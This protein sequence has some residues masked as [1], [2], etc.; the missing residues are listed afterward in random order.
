MLYRVRLMFE[1][2]GGCIWCGNDAA[3]ERFSVGSI[4]ENLPL[5][6]ATLQKLH[7]LTAWHDKALNWDY[8]PDPSPWSQEE[9]RA[10]ETAAH[11]MRSRL[12]TE[13]GPEF[14]VVYESSP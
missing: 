11:D 2:G 10:F 7:A 13:L 14:E 12:Q 3:R 1:W 8:P 5:S 6:E 4:E 9:F